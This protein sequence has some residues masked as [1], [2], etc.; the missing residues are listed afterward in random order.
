M[1]TTEQSRGHSL[2]VAFVP[3]RVES[4]PVMIVLALVM[5]VFVPVTTVHEDLNVQVCSE[6][7]F[8]L[9]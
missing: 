1:L 9:C 4:V 3:V 6:L 2:V 5:I 8:Q 7:L